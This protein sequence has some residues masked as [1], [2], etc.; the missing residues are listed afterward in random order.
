MCWTEKG[1]FVSYEF[2]FSVVGRKNVFSSFFFIWKV[3]W[4][5]SESCSVSMSV[6]TFD[7]TDLVRINKNRILFSVFTTKNEHLTTKPV[8]LILAF[9]C[10]FIFYLFRQ[11]V[12]V[13]WSQTATAKLFSW[14]ITRTSNQA[15]MP[16]CTLT[17]QKNKKTN[18]V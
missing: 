5:C 10:L 9:I 18:Y 2:N 8:V 6:Q 13:T 14:Y 15:L 7:D 3:V 11:Q 17:A 16:L 4:S 12:T 1:V